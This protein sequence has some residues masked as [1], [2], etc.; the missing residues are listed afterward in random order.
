MTT[1]YQ[2]TQTG[3]PV[4][5]VRLGLPAAGPGAAAGVGR[6]LLGM[7]V[8]IVASYLVA[9]LFVHKTA[10]GVPAPGAWASLV[11]LIE[12]TV[13]IS[14]AGQTIGMYAVHVR[15]ISLT[16]GR[17]QPWWALART[18][19]LLL[20]VPAVIWDADRRGLH[21]KASGAIVVNT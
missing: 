20:L 8:D 17:L 4:P 15:V 9:A 7:A 21:D 18:V 13:L 5:G 16:G 14:V 2:Q 1:N 19:L 3:E 12:S 10:G 11:F 6:R